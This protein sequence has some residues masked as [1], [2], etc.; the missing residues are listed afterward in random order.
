MQQYSNLSPATCNALDALAAKHPVCCG[1]DLLARA[2]K[3]ARQTQ[4]DLATPEQVDMYIFLKHRPECG[5]D[6][7]DECPVTGQPANN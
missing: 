2:A 6:C 4:P 7:D 3:V 1:R 5:M